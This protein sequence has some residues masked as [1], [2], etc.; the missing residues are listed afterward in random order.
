V[1]ET[2]VDESLVHLVVSSLKAKI[3]QGR[4]EDGSSKSIRKAMQIAESFAVDGHQKKD[5]V[6]AALNL[7]STHAPEKWTSTLQVASTQ[8]DELFKLAQGLSSLN[9]NSTLAD[10]KGQ[11]D[12]L[13]ESK[14]LSS[15]FPCLKKKSKK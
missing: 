12:A 10:V 5:I 3:S 8:I 14:A 9:K 4:L 1:D 11:L 2:K 7:L 6:L 15:C 13:A